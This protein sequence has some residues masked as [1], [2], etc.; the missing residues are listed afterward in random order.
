MVFEK[1]S[2]R[3]RVSFEVGAAQLGA[4]AVMLSSRDAQLGRGEPIRDT[5]RVMARYVDGSSCG[6]MPTPPP[7]RWPASP[8]S[9]W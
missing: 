4:T 7:R 3:T 5:A 8:T 2:T 1:A 6:P 9:R